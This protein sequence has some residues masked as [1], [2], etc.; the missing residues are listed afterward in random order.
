MR[1]FT[2]TTTMRLTA[3]YSITKSR[4]S[5]SAN[6]VSRGTSHSPIKS[7]ESGTSSWVA[8]LL[9][10][11]ASNSLRNS[12]PTA[13]LSPVKLIKRKVELPRALAG[14]SFKNRSQLRQPLMLLTI[15]L[16]KS[17]LQAT[18][19]NSPL[20]ITTP[21]K[22]VA[23]SSL[24]SLPRSLMKIPSARNSLY[25]ALSRACLY[26]TPKYPPQHL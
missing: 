23:S 12:P 1:L 24:T 11:V 20:P 25:S 22:V 2:S 26:C 4:N 17:T 7:V 5:E 19:S 21:I 6:T 3:C 13:L 18:S 16:S 10:G 9:P 14:S 8:S 15:N